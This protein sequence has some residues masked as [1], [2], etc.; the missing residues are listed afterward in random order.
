MKF[1][2]SSLSHLMQDPQTDDMLCSLNAIARQPHGMIRETKEVIALARRFNREVVRPY[3]SQLDREVQRDPD[4]IPYDFVKKA[5]QWGLYTKWLPRMFGGQGYNLPSLSY[6]L[7]EI[8][9]ACVAMANLIGVH[10]LGVGALI[11]AWQIRIAQRIF[12]EVIEGEQ[13]D[14]PCLIS[15]ALTEPD[16]GTDAEDIDLMERGRMTCH[17][18]KVNG[19]YT[20]NGNK[21]FISN[22]HLSTWHIVF[23]FADLSCPSSNLVLLAV[24]TNSQGFSFG[25]IEHKM[26]QKGCPASELIFKDCF[27]P[28]DQVCIDPH[29]AKSLKRSVSKTTEQVID[30]VLAASRCGVGAFGTGVARGAY[31]CALEFASKTEI[32]GKLLI[33]Y[34]W[35]QTILAQMYRN[36]VISRMAYVEGNYAVGMYG[37]YKLLQWKP[38]FYFLK[39]LPAGIISFLFPAILKQ[40]WL[41]R[42]MRYIQLDKQSLVEIQRT[43]GLG[44][45]AK[46]SGADLAMTNCQLALE[47]MGDAGLR[48]E[49]LAEKFFR[50]AKLIQIYEGTNQLNRLNLFKC[51][52]APSV[53]QVQMFE[54]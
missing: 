52:I 50:D 25:R 29:Q 10:Y 30:Y 9:S 1:S 15:F 51:L 27:V 12:Q 17:A 2:R 48:Q 23:A 46:F 44:S 42:L 37:M 36:T 22:G 24:K 31:E 32:C 3:A 35:A 13:N 28:D 6:F 8:S 43:S 47:L 19:G 41:T 7:E 4:F 45:L 49:N 38:V 53:P 54:Q 39:Y 14:K 33:N 21:I 40:P 11:S 5:N 26:G 20:V 34:E 16:A 18:R